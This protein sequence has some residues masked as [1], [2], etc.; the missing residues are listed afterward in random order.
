M[1]KRLNMTIIFGIIKIKKKS[2]DSYINNIIRLIIKRIFNMN[3]F[4]YYL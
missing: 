3:K 2:A 4:I 1:I